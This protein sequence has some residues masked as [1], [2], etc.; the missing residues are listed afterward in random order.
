MIIKLIQLK[1]SLY[2]FPL[3]RDPYPAVLLVRDHRHLAVGRATPGLRSA[4]DASHVLHLQY[5]SGTCKPSLI[6]D[7]ENS[8]QS[9][10]KAERQG[11]V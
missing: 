10:N 3:R 4:L 1:I 11:Q 6:A 5:H 9:I 8:Q 7:K 2:F